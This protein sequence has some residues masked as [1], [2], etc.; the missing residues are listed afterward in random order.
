VGLRSRDLAGGPG[1]FARLRRF[2][3]LRSRP[4][5]RRRMLPLELSQ[6]PSRAFARGVPCG[7]R[8]RAFALFAGI[9]DRVVDMCVDRPRG[10]LGEGQGPLQDRPPVRRPCDV[11]AEGHG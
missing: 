2:A 11:G 4:I 7:Y 6:Q 1:G 8:E 9:H 3:R 10:Q 5:S